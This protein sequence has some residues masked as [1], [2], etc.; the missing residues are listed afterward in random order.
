[1]LAQ[2]ALRAAT[3]PCANMVSNTSKYMG[4]VTLAEAT[5]SRQ[6]AGVRSSR[7]C[8]DRMKSRMASS[9]SNSERFWRGP[10][11]DTPNKP[12]TCTLACVPS[13]S[14]HSQPSVRTH[15]RTADRCCRYATAEES[16]RNNGD[17]DA[18]NTVPPVARAADSRGAHCAP[19]TR[20]P[21]VLDAFN[22]AT[23]CAACFATR[24]AISVNINDPTG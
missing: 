14:R 12:H 18:V 17:T 21:L 24:V 22:S 4:T 20:R 8:F 23:T 11:S 15:T 6:E 13:Q 3:V 9:S 5:S 1:M 7:N 2:G 10:Y 16:P 19:P